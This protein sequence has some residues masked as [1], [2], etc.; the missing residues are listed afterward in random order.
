VTPLVSVSLLCLNRLDLTRRC[1]ESL[2]AHTPGPWELHITDNGS[3]DGTG[4][5]LRALAAERAAVRLTTHGANRG[6]IAPHNAQAA[7]AAGQWLCVLNNDTEVGPGWLDALL[8]PFRADPLV[9]QVGPA[10]PYGALTADFLGVPCAPG[11]APEYLSGHCFVVPRRLGQLHGLFD[12][13]SLAWATCEDADLSLRLRRAGY[14][15]VRVPDAP[16]RH[17]GR[18]TMDG[19]DR[20]L[21]GYD[22]AE[23]ELRNRAAMRARWA[24]YLRDRAFGRWR[25]LVRRG[26]AFGDVL[27]VE[28]ILR[29]LREKYPAAHIT[30][31][32]TPGYLPGIAHSP[33]ADRFTTDTGF[34]RRRGEFDEVIDLDDA[35]EREPRT[36]L[37]AAYARAAGV[38]PDRPRWHLDE[39]GRQMAASLADG[40]PLCV[41]SSDGGWPIRTW[42]LDRLRE[43]ARRLEARFRV[44]EVG[45][46]TRVG[47]GRSLCGRTTLQQLAG[48]YSR[49][50]LAVLCDSLHVHLAAC[51][52]VP[53]VGVWGG[54]DPALRVHGPEHTAVRREGF[55][56]LA[57]HHDRPAPRHHSDCD[58][59]AFR[60]LAVGDCACLDVPVEA[61]WAAVEKAAG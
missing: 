17:L 55:P 51:F 34:L 25:V 6:F 22:P 15:I 24:G 13:A 14:K 45:G 12:E 10:D 54:T 33:A 46:A 4:D 58:R 59:G 56:C 5:Y 20:H 18:A 43:V 39:Q 57:C 44:V 3:T 28:P 16:V 11:A 23:N 26:S 9:G 38:L 29:G 35:Y 19:P 2:V 42:P 8:A 41:V 7:A 30:M 50:R 27:C 1:V 52:A 48:V 40:P 61:V 53:T 31:L 49:A 47:V 37:V 32:T 36:H 21:L 60:G